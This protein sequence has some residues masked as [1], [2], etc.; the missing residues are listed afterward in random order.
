[1]KLIIHS[2]SNKIG[3]SCVELKT[4]TARILIDFG[5]PLVGEAREPFDQRSLIGKSIED[6]KTSKILPDVKGLYKTEERSI[7]AI[8]ISHSHLD[9][10]GLLN[11]A[12]PDIPVY[13]TAG[14]NEL[15]NV[16]NI[17]TPNRIDHVNARIIKS[18]KQ[19]DIKDMA[20]MPY[21]VDH[22]AFDALAFLVESGGKRVFYSGDF[23]GHGRKS[24]LFDMMVEDPPKDIDCL[25]MEGSMIGRGEQEYKNEIAVQSRIEDILK[26]AKNISFL[27]MSAQNIDRVVSA[28]KACLRTGSTLVIDIYAAFVLDKLR[29]VS[30]SIPQ[31]NWKNIRVK[32]FSDHAEALTKAGYRDLLFVYNKRKIDY[33]EINKKKSRILMMARNNS[34]FPKMLKELGDTKGSKIVY[35]MWMGYLTDKFKEYCGKKG[36]E[37]E[38]VHTSGHATLENLK[39]FAAALNPKALLPI[40]TFEADQFP[41]LFKNVRIVRDEE[42]FQV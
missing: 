36:L 3:G 11:Y 14:A 10:Y 40:H 16:S 27:F 26:E 24:A 32:F 37:I 30:K 19:F 29:K 17:F 9:H 22:S 38:P 20:I 28:Y 6:L 21:Q 31:F 5:M 7:D 42:E 4:D 8:L 41:Q 18:G 39:T 1:M 34:V 35:S 23:R 2:G 25:V 13:M 33:L 15:I 12:H